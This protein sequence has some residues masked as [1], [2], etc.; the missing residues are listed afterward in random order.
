M[1][2]QAIQN[3]WLIV[4]AISTA[5]LIAIAI[6]KWRMYVYTGTYYFLSQAILITVIAHEQFSAEI[7]NYYHPVPVDDPFTGYYWLA[8]RVLEM[9]VSAAVL[10]YMVFGRNGK[11]KAS[12][13]TD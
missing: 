3:T 4:T 7:K 6:Y 11:S 2:P 8:S 5:I 9:V 1:T 13:S 12:K 10:G